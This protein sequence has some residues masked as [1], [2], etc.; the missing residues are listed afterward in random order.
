[1]SSKLNDILIKNLRN[2]WESIEKGSMKVTRGKT[3]A[4]LGTLLDFSAI[5]VVKISMLDYVMELVKEL[6]I[7]I[8]VKKSL[9]QY[10]LFKVREEDQE[11]RLSQEI[12]E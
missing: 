6:E 12:S 7:I 11:K 5:G 10:W 8:K 4:C 2:K 1:M 3:H 9:D